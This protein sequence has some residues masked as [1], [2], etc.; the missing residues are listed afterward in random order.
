MLPVVEINGRTIG[1]GQPG[2][3]YQKLLTAWGDHTGVDIANQARQFA[4]RA[5]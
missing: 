2:P 5:S 1:D 4:Q 3:T